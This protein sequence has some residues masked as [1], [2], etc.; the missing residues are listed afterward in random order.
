MVNRATEGMKQ[1]EKQRE[2]DDGGRIEDFARRL[3]RS[4]TQTS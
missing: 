2:E 3:A 1:G 4:T